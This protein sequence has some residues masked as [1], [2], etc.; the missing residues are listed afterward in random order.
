MPGCSAFSL[1]PS[2]ASNDQSVNIPL[3]QGPVGQCILIAEDNDAD[4]L[5]LQR[6][7]KFAGVPCTVHAVPDGEE[8]IAY[9]AGQGKYVNRVEFPLPSLV[10]LDLKM[11][12]KGGF[13]VLRWIRTHPKFCR[14]PVLVMTVS[15]QSAD[16]NR[17]YALGANSFINKSLDYQSTKDLV[18]SIRN[19]WLTLTCNPRPDPSP[20]PADQ[21]ET[22]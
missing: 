2:M 18:Q 8:A 14:L 4:L 3:S 15:N 11:P 13:E 19:F 7:L 1:S 10:L 5:L 6:A 21:G 20:L 16:I 22:L 17:A 12:N 9:L